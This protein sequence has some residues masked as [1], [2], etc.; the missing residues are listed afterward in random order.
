MQS[1]GGDQEIFERDA[2][3]LSRSFALDSPG[4]P[5]DFDRHRMNRNIPDKFIYERLP[6]RP[7]LLIL[8]SLYT[9]NQFDYGHYG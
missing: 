5:G 4:T 6:P 3:A 7:A 8:S 2:D 1:S 9:M